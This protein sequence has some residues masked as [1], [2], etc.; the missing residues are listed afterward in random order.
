MLALVFDGSAILSSTYP[1]PRLIKGE[2]VVAVR[3][4]GL[5]STDLEILK[6]YMGF[7]GVMGHEFVGVVAEGP[8]AWLGKRVVAEINCVCGRCDMCR[9]GSSNHCRDRT[10]LGID[11]RDGVLAQYVAIPVRNLHEVPGAVSDEAA[12]FVEPLAAAFQVL[13]QVKCSSGDEA[14]VLGDGRLGQLVARVLHGRLRKLVLVG[15]HE[16]KL[17]AAEKAG[18][19]TVLESDFI[20]RAKADLVVD[21][22][23]SPSGL[24]L[25][26]KTVRPRGTIVLKSTTAAGAEGLN[27]A[28]I[29]INEVTIVGS[30]CGPFHEALEALARGEI[31]VSPLVSRRF[32][33]GDALA[34]LAAAK[35]PQN[36]KVLIDV[37]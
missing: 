10:V 3:L 25:A 32:A 19:Q 14:V 18:V 29:V 26:M 6:G 15:R 4:A 24:E 1:V 33:L 11:R 9:R 28:P 27:L 35:A 7:R 34:A 23:G 20:P 21:A 37:C 22:T 36:I 5:C 13:R 2:V 17:E 30:R 31:D 8:K 12:V 16:G